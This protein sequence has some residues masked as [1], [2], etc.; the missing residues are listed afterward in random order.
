MEKPKEQVLFPSKQFV[1][2]SKED[3]EEPGYVLNAIATDMSIR[4]MIKNHWDDQPKE[5]PQSEEIEDELP[6]YQG[7]VHIPEDQKI[8]RKILEL[9]H[10]SP[11]AGH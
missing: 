2:C 3:Q 11:M 7:R 6:L 1:D 5:A 4:D 9:Y 10:D 8:K